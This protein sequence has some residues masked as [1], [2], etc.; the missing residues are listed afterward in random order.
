MSTIYT[1]NGKVLK[2]VTTGKWLAKKE[3]PAG[4]VLNASNSVGTSSGNTV[5]YWNG[6]NYPEGCNLEGKTIIVTVS[7]SITLPFQSWRICYASRTDGQ[8]ERLPIIDYQRPANQIIEPGTYTFTALG[9]TAPSSYNYG[10]YIALDS[11]NNSDVSKITI[12]IL[13]V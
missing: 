8:E 9:H 11:I 10:K 4:M 7:E 12:Q 1:I 6:P 3:A 13:G 2:N 5:T